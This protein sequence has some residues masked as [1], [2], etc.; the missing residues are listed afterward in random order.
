[1][2]MI[3]LSEETLK[4]LDDDIEKHNKTNPPTD[5]SGYLSYLLQQ[6]KKRK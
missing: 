5:R 3:Y 1:M 2:A 4:E 6:N